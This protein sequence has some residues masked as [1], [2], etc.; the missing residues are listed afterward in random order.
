MTYKTFTNNDPFF[1][2]TVEKIGLLDA[3]SIK[4]KIEKYST[5]V[6]LYLIN[7]VKGIQLFASDERS[8]NAIDNSMRF[9]RGEITQKELVAWPSRKHEPAVVQGELAKLK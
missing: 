3:L 6:Q 2:L 7:C 4:Y 8:K 5:M 9:I 1:S